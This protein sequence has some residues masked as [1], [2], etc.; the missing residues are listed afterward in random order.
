MRNGNLHILD[1]CHNIFIIII[2]KIDA[3]VSIYWSGSRIAIK[4]L[5]RKSN[6][7]RI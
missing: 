6:K 5:A 7:E 3:L 4:E 2:P 1:I